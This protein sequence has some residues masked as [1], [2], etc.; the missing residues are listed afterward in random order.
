LWQYLRRDRLGVRFRRQHALDRYIVDFY[1]SECQLAI[2]VDGDVHD[3]Q[4]E[5]DAVR[6]QHLARLGIHMLR[7]RNDEVLDNPAQVIAAIEARI[8]EFKQSPSDPTNA[9]SLPS[10][11]GVGGR[12]PDNAKAGRG[13]NPA[14]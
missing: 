9:P 3:T 10:G 6:E 11:E 12:N 8:A 7:F 5:S 1:A 14:G 4:R 13:F 2:E